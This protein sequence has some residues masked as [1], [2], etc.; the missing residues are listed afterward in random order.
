MHMLYNR[1]RSAFKHKY[2]HYAA[3]VQEVDY[4]KQTMYVPW[5]HS[6]DDHRIWGTNRGRVPLNFLFLYNGS[7][8]IDSTPVEEDL[9]GKPY[10]E[11]TDDE[12]YENSSND[13]GATMIK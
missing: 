7:L 12:D 6:E 5:L 1:E 3:V 10:I 11:S 9:F 2:V 8:N 4:E 13:D